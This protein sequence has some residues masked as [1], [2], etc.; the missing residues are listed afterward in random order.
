MDKI[1]ISGIYEKT[2]KI[3]QTKKKEVTNLQRY[4]KKLRY[5]LLIKTVVLLIKT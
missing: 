2:N 4:D 3:K 5:L 1:L